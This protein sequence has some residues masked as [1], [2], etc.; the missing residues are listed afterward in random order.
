MRK[1]SLYY[2]NATD[3][4]LVGEVISCSGSFKICD[5]AVITAGQL[6]NL[7]RYPTKEKTNRLVGRE[8]AQVDM[9]T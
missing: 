5:E 4:A 1:S 3:K 9:E 6:A 8:W 7:K 2:A